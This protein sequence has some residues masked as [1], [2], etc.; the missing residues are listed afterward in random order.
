MR[1][2]LDTN[3]V[4]SAML[5][6]G[7]PLI[8]LDAAREKRV[9]LCT[10]TALLAELTDVLNREKFKKKIAAS[11]LSVDQLV[12]R[13]ADLTTLVRPV[14]ISGVAPDAKDDVVLGTALAAHAQWIVTGDKPLLAVREHQGVR[15]IPVSE[16]IQSLQA[17]NA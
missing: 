9:M 14:L 12:D 15:I 7:T 10:S 8:L 3:V 5:W 13:Y 2:V 16:A 17:L 1:L 11:P 6:G 4:A